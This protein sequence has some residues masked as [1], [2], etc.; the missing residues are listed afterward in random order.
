MNGTDSASCLLVG[1]GISSVGHFDYASVRFACLL[2]GKIHNRQF[3][4][5]RESWRNCCILTCLVYIYINTSVNQNSGLPKF[6]TLFLIF[7]LIPS[8]SL[9]FLASLFLVRVKES[10]SK[11]GVSMA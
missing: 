10:T 3:L 6:W 1:C 5:Y 4:G 7:S 11:V 9:T 8:E 2:L